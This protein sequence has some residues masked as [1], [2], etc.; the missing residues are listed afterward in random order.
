MEISSQTD[1]SEIEKLRMI[2]KIIDLSSD[3]LV[4]ELSELLYD[5]LFIFDRGIDKTK[6][7]LKKIRYVFGFY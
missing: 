2:E 5:D 3:E 6:S 1:D 7:N 4:Y